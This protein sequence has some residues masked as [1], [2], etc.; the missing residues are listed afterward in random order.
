VLE[1]ICLKIQNDK[2]CNFD[3]EKSKFQSDLSKEVSERLD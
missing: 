3:F 2:D 1:G